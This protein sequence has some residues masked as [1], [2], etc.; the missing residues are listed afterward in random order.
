MRVASQIASGALE[1]PVPVGAG[2]RAERLVEGAPYAG[3]GR[4]GHVDPRAVGEAVAA[5]RVDR[6]E[7]DDSSSGAP[8]LRNRSR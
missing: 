8:V 3:A 4:V 2:A 6:H 7:V 1:E 5:G